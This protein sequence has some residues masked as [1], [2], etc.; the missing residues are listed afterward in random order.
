M[1]AER[2]VKEAN[3]TAENILSESETVRRAKEE[4]KRIQER[5]VQHCEAMKGEA[6]QEAKI[7]NVR[8]IR[9]QRV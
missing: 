7:L 6:V 9:K 2:I 4:E 1:R 8:H 5:L 3:D